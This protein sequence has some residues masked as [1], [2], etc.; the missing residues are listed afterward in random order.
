MVEA[1]FALILHSSNPAQATAPTLL[2]PGRSRRT[3]HR[4]RGANLTPPAQRA[5]T[6]SHHGRIRLSW[7]APV[8]F[9]AFAVREKRRPKS[10]AHSTSGSERRSSH[11]RPLSPPPAGWEAFACVPCSRR[12][13]GRHYLYRSSA[14][15]PYPSLGWLAR[16]RTWPLLHIRRPPPCPMSTTTPT[17]ALAVRL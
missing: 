17:R 16:L 13:R 12:S 2:E 11:S 6:L 1:I 10:V 7:P 15:F 8:P 4:H 9:F 14:A 3:R 5:S